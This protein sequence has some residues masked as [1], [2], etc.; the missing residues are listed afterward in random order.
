MIFKIKLKLKHFCCFQ[1]VETQTRKT[2][3]ASPSNGENI[4]VPKVSY[5]DVGGYGKQVA[6]LRSII[7]LPLHHAD[8]YKDIGTKPPRGVLLWGPPGTG[9]TLIARYTQLWNSRQIIV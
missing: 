5:S 2:R 4:A 1:S 9:K 3:S 8:L 7:T 6:E